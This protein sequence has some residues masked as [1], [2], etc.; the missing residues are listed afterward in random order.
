MIDPNLL[1][2][3]TK[4]RTT[5][6]EFLRGLGSIRYEISDE[7]LTGLYLVHPGDSQIK[8]KLSGKKLEELAIWLFQGAIDFIPS[9]VYLLKKVIDEGLHGHRFYLTDEEAAGLLFKISNPSDCNVPVSTAKRNVL[10]PFWEKKRFNVE[11]NDRSLHVGFVFILEH[12]SQGYYI[13]RIPE[14]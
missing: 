3:V 2:E 1:N 13:D 4:L 10:I 8:E 14:K 7:V 11:Q 12:N 6:Q 5:P 9:H